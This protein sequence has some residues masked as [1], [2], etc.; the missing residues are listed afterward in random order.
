MTHR[1]RHVLWAVIAVGFALRLAWALYARGE[2]P[3]DWRQSGDQFSYYH[4]G[5][6]I[7]RG[8][9]YIS[10]I[11]GEATAYYP[12]GY[13]AILGVLFFVVLHTPIPDDLMLATA[14]LHVVLARRRWRSPSWSDGP[15][16]ACGSGSSPRRCS[17]R[18]RT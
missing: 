6:E 3:T 11:T 16:P 17:P 9:G 18:S 7:A 8:R 1:Q 13:P 15:W 2:A 5:S 10:Y 4:Y 12:I 14:L